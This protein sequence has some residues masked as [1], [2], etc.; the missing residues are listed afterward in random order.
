MS[1]EGSLLAGAI[2]AQRADRLVYVVRHLSANDER[3]TCPSDLRSGRIQLINQIA[4]HEQHSRSSQHGIYQH[5]SHKV[6]FH[7]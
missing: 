6:S 3:A 1:S 4:K 2:G 7:N 5:V